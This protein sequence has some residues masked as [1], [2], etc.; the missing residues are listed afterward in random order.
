M[1]GNEV[2]IILEDVDKKFQTLMEGINSVR[3]E[4]QRHDQKK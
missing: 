2:K 3:E 1:K 4:L